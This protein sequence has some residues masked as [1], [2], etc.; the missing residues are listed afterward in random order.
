MCNKT[1]QISVM[2]C[3]YNAEGFIREAIDSI[4]CQTYKDFEL[5]IVDD[6]STDKT[7]QIIHKYKDSRIKLIEGNHDYIKSLNTG[8]H[9]CRGEFI[10]RIDADDRMLPYR[11]E[12]QLAIMNE[13][14]DI[15]A[16]FS[17]AEKFGAA[18]GVHGIDAKGKVNNAI[19]W[20]L[21][22]NFL[23]HPSVMLRKSFIK[24]H[25]LYY[26]RYPYAEDYKLWVDIA[27]LGDYFY[28]IPESLIQYRISKSQVSYRYNDEQRLSKLSIQ[29]EILE[30]LLKCINH[31]QRENLRRLYNIMLKLNNADMVEPKELVVFMYKLLRRTNLFD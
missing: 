9:N 15:A 18:S 28:V 25:H 14:P 3:A 30:H 24:Q 20:L 23:V 5:V 13:Y 31:P 17:W 2:L 11:L 26:K 10:A 21:A 16:C 27:R 29:Q 8:M 12:K 7:R 19:F 6:G 4:L 1:P 22:G